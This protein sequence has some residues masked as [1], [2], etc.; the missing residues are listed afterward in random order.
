MVWP[1]LAA[2][3]AASA[4]SSMGKGRGLSQVPLIGGFFNDP[5][6]E[7]LENSMRQYGMAAAA[8]A[9]V[10]QQQWQNLR[11]Q[12]DQA[13]APARTAL[14]Q[15]Y[16]GTPVEQPPPPVGMGDAGMAME[17]MHRPQIGKEYPAF[18]PVT[19]MTST[20]PVNAGGERRKATSGGQKRGYGGR[21]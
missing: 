15:L 12:V 7:R 13:Y 18:E 4:A 20:G 1:L 3:M 21:G 2:Y 17:Q 11:G 6:Q 9:P 19:Y 8:R 5:A 10:V 14:A 16:A